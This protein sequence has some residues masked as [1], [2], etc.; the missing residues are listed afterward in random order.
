MLT[1]ASLVDAPPGKLA[2][3]AKSYPA[4]SPTLAQARRTPVGKQYMKNPP[5]AAQGHLT[6]TTVNV[7]SRDRNNLVDVSSNRRARD[8]LLGLPPVMRVEDPRRSQPSRGCPT[9][10]VERTG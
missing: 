9:L 8:D 2:H 3:L 1:A 5:D 4:E 6:R 7:V 10:P